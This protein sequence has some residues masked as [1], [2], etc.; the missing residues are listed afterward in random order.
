MYTLYSSKDKIN[1]EFEEQNKSLPESI[2]AL[3]KW[4]AIRAM[5][6]DENIAKDNRWSNPIR[7]YWFIFE[8]TNN[9]D[10]KLVGSAFIDIKRHT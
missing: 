2:K 5:N 6:I 1:F 8:G 10:G 3:G 7:E 4:L 9:I